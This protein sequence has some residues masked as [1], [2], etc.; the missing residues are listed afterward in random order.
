MLQ[1]HAFRAIIIKYWPLPFHFH[2]LL[3][4]YVH[5]EMRRLPK[6]EHK[7]CV[8]IHVLSLSRV[9]YVTWKA[10][11][12]QLSCAELRTNTIMYPYAT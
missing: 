4:C 7:V 5:R 11:S 12:L 10:R 3:Q 2:N 9:T 8:L 6:V 1:I